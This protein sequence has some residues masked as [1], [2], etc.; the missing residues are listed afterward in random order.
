MAKALGI[1]LLFARVSLQQKDPL[2][3]FCRRF[4]HQSCVV[5]TKLYIDGGQVNWTPITADRQNY[6]NTWESYHDLTTSP[7]GVGVPQLHANLSKNSTIPDVSGAVLWPD[8][9]NKRFYLFGGDNYQDS[10]SVANLYSYDILYDKWDSF[11]TPSQGIQSVSWGAS[12]GISDIGQGY[13]LGGLLSNYSVPGWNGSPFATNSLLSYDMDKQ[14]W[15]NNTGPSDNVARAEGVMVYVPASDSGMLIQFGGVTVDVNGTTDASPMEKINVYDV[16][17]GKWYTQTASGSVPPTRRR[18]CA[19]AAWAPDHSSY[20]IYIYGGLGFGANG[21]GF[22]DVW[23]LSLPS[24]KWIPFYDGGT[25]GFPHHSLTCNVVGGQMLVTGGTFPLSDACDSSVTWG[26]HSLD[27]GKVSGRQWNPYSVNITEY[28]VPPEVISIVGGFDYSM[29]SA[30]GLRST[31]GATATAPV[32]GFD[33]NDL[34][35][36]FTQ[37]ASIAS[38]T[39][40]R[41]I[42]VAT[43]SAIPPAKSSSSVKITGAA[44]AGIAVGGGLFLI[45]LI[46]G[47]CFLLRRKRSKPMPPAITIPDSSKPPY[48]TPYSVPFSPQSQ[49]SQPYSHDGMFKPG[50]HHQLPTT[51]EPVELYGSDY[52]RKGQTEGDGLDLSKPHP[53]Y[54]RRTPGSLKSSYSDAGTHFSRSNTVGSNTFAISPATPVYHNLE[55]SPPPM[56]PLNHF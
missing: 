12:V 46:L 56:P 10:P 3:D 49:Y 19:G 13:I 39:A 9:V 35:V 31:G 36:Y 38:R 37:K 54:P 40:S 29:D 5:D 20:N 16:K 7:A 52:L 2:R 23:I 32:N 41:A 17:S 15:S 11:G 24:F 14:A 4:G 27:M 21:P 30:D 1:L 26:M 22:D 28:V 55:R 18:F 47:A 6:T 50:L 51:P 44:V 34:G 8:A 33:N 45:T 48:P 42:P 43:Q 53:P 25:S